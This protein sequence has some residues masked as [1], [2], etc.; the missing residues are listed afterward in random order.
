MLFFILALLHT[1]YAVEKSFASK[2]YHSGHKKAIIASDSHCSGNIL[3]V[4][5]FITY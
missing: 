3:A 4:I 1:L 2:S 5:T